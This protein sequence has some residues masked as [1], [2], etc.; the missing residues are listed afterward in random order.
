MATN[1][2]DD[3]E[4]RIPLILFD[5]VCNLCNATVRW[6]IEKDPEGQFHFAS[7]QSEAGQAAVARAAGTHPVGLDE[8]ADLRSVV[9]IDESGVHLRSDAALRV[10]RRLGLP[11]SL[12]A[13]ASVIPRTIRDA[14][15]EWVARNRY[16]W[17]GKQ[18]TCPVPSAELRT[19]FIGVEES[20]PTTDEAG[21]R[22]GEHDVQ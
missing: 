21:P 13:I 7:L 10:A 11:W 22:D 12:F 19:R 16:R 17:F 9:L 2:P 1:V 5:G 15:Y 6:V 8:A 3:V 20:N 18:L 14:I 4:P